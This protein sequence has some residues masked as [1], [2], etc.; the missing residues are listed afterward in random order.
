MNKFLLA[1]NPIIPNTGLFIIHCLP[2]L[3]IIEACKSPPNKC[4]S[5]QVETGN[6]IW[7]LVLISIEPADPFTVDKV[8]KRA[9]YWFKAYR[10]LSNVVPALSK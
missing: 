8:L 3:A 6:E 7:F 10:E 9:M 2:P 5:L 1:Y 4:H